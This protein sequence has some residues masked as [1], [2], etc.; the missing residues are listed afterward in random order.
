MSFFA[1]LKRRNVFRVGIAYA[2][3]A[4]LLIQVSDILLDSIGAPSWVLQTLFVVLAVGF[5]IALFFAWAFELTPDGVKREKE[6]DRSQSITPQTG[7]KLNNAILV[8]M[9]L[10]IGY[11]LFDKFSGPTQP[12]AQ[13]GSDPFSQQAV[14]QSTQS[15]EKRALTPDEAIAQASVT[16][17][18][19]A[20]LPFV[21][22][23]EDASNEYFSDGLT[24]EVLNILAKIKEMRVAGRTSSFAFKGKDDDLRTIGEKLNVQSILEGSVRKD[25]ARNRVRITAQLV[26]VEDGYHLWSETYDRDLDDIF[27]IQ[28]EIA[29]KVADALKVTLLGEDEARIAA[30]A[31][32]DLSAYDLYLRGLQQ[33]NVHSFAAL[34]EARTA[35]TRAVELDPNYQP[36]RLK[37][38]RA[39]LDLAITGAISNAE[40]IATSQPILV[41]ILE[42]DP[43]NA[44][45]HVLM[46]RL[47]AASQ[48][49]NNSEQ[50]L[51]LALD[52]DPRNVEALRETG[53]YIFLGRDVKK[54]LEYVEEAGRIDPYS[55]DVLWDLM[56]FYA[57]TGQPELSLPYAQRTAEIQPE[58]PNRYWGPGMGY[59]LSGQLAT[60]MDY[61]AKAA[62]LD[63]L[64]PELPAGIATTW[65]DLGD[66]EQAEKWAKLAD[67]LGAD[68]PSPIATRVQLYQYR[69]QHGL[70]ADMAK[71]ALDRNL[72]NRAGTNNV[73]RRTYIANLVRQGN[74]QAGI[75]FY[76]TQFP[77]AFA[78]PLDVD[79]DSF[80]QSEQLLEI[81][82]LLQMG[83]PAS[84]KADE[85][86]N[87]AEQKMQLVD[88]RFI[89]WARALDRASIAAARHDKQAALVQLERAFDLGLRARWR[90]H[91]MSTIAFNSLHDEPEFK[92]LIAR[93]EADMDQQRER[94]YKIPGVL[95]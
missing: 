48:E 20:V 46:A 91:L 92:Q 21:N 15:E 90:N 16:H 68:Q 88:E 82:L 51:K 79:M 18:S 5:V 57:F 24:E 35:F 58:N 37:L 66:P 71:R 17:H 64:D 86:I 59:M 76:L 77:G 61:Q 54:G 52:S 41:S 28:E 84:A 9:A 62:A 87:A 67:E 94:A 53:R 3:T 22:M 40:A 69:E 39:W 72:D 4:W 30:Q 1:E 42:Q 93:F 43:A 81:A 78:T 70:A 25:E 49:H 10:A 34:N 14:S 29:R 8:L 63:T 12:G 56:A 73:F 47:M 7:K 27:A 23:S 95:R 60:A 36:A 38:A 50:E 33:L 2:V 19:I 85:L 44:E 74:I 75:D 80:R 26:N 11:L 65:I 31:V 32:T 6:V 83:D 89:P 13:P 55:V 45:A